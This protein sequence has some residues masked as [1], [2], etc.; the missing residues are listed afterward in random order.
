MPRRR[1]NGDAPVA[2]P[3]RTS[4]T[5]SGFSPRS[6]NKPRTARAV[7]PC[8]TPRWVLPVASSAW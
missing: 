4:S 8:S 6:R 2:A 7:S 5:L 1:S 3:S